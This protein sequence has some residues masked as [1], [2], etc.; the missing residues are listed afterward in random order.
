MRTCKNGVRWLYKLETEDFV[1]ES[2]HSVP[3]TMEFFDEG[4]KKRLEIAK[5]GRITVKQ[6]YAWDGCTPKL[7]F[8]DILFGTPDGVVH[9]KSGKTK[10]YYASLVHDAFYQFLSEI[11]RIAQISR[12]DADDFFYRIMEEYEFAPRWI[13]WLAVRLFGGI[14]MSVRMNITRKTQGTMKAL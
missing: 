10:T 1:W 11:P 9:R 6:G 4:G 2:G 8:F 7:C 13:Y 14:G 3:Y 5:D 12:R